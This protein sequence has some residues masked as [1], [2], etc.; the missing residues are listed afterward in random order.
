MRY[1]YVC[2]ECGDQ[3]TIQAPISEGPPTEVLC[4]PPCEA[5]VHRVYTAPQITV[6]YGATDYIE[7]AYRGETSVPGLT[8]S[9]VRGIVDVKTSEA[10]RGRANNE[11]LHARRHRSRDRARR[12][13]R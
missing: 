6:H 11:R 4:R 8:T 12:T 9:A 13:A 5:V 2:D 1:E 3:F 10:R 7:Q